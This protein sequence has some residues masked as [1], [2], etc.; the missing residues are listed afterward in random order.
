M[1]SIKE[2]VKVMRKLFVIR[3]DAYGTRALDRDVIWQVKRPLTD[4]ILLAHLH[5]ITPVGTY[6]LSLDGAIKWVCIDLD[7]E[8]YGQVR[9]LKMRCQHYNLPTY[10]EKS[11]SRGYHVWGFHQHPIPAYKAR[12]VFK[13]I[14]FDMDMQATELF[15]KQ[16]RPRNNGFGNFVWLP[17]FGYLKNNGLARQGR[18]VFVDDHNIPYPDQFRVLSS[19]Q[20]ISEGKLDDII[21]I[22][23]LAADGTTDEGDTLEGRRG[24]ESSASHKAHKDDHFF[25]PPC[26]RRILGAGIAEGLRNEAGFRL[27]ILLLRTG[28]PDDLAWV[29][30]GHWNKKN[31]PPLPAEELEKAF[32]QGYSGQYKSYGCHRLAAFC[33]ERCPIFKYRKKVGWQ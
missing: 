31:R 6:S 33:S 9:E 26:L 16:D 7:H 21:E 13:N 12:A 27:A 8:D 5:G 29:M 15:P 20:T 19:V 3:F 1:E 23:D 25:A 2:I 17:L 11:K 30:L 22:N 18:T 4:A 10:I 32:H 24:P 14:L 28:I